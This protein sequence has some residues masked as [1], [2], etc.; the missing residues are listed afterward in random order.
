MS[1]PETQ[2]QAQASGPRACVHYECLRNAAL[3]FITRHCEFCVCL[4]ACVCV[5]ACMHT[6]RPWPY[7]CVCVFIWPPRAGWLACL[8]PSS[9]AQA[10]P[11]GHSVTGRDQAFCEGCSGQSFHGV[12][13]LCASCMA[14][15]ASPPLHPGPGALLG[16]SGPDPRL[17]TLSPQGAARLPSHTP[18]SLPAWPTP[19]LLPAP[20][21]T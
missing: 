21:A 2:V 9:S 6:Q 14:N 12:N 20:R 8:P 13:S 3:H 7:Q 1:E 17:P 11:Q 16:C 18:S 10:T 5:C 4:C 19:S 15:S